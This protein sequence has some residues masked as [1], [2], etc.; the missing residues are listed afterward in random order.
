MIAITNKNPSVLHLN[1]VQ[2][3][4]G[5]EFYNFI[6]CLCLSFRGG[7]LLSPGRF[8][9]THTGTCMNT[10]N[11]ESLWFC[12][13]LQENLRCHSF[14]ILICLFYIRSQFVWSPP[15]RLTCWHMSDSQRFPS[16]CF[17]NIKIIGTSI[18]HI[19]LFNMGF[20]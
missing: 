8:V 13:R 18:Y 11:T 5:I 16:L 15:S 20:G 10:S 4:Y 6:I 2:W 3:L 17:S 9:C 14:S 7:Y 1:K 12:T 19:P